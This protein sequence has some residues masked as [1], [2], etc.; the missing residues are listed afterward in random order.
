MADQV[1]GKGSLSKNEKKSSDKHPGMIG[2]V[3]FSDD[4]PAGTKLYAAT[5]LNQGDNGA[6]I[7][8]R[9]SWPQERSESPPDE[10]R[11]PRPRM[12]ELDIPF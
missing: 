6:Y 11:S 3:T 4:I 2:S 1:A 10:R 8:L 5:W 12:Q 9:L 7:S